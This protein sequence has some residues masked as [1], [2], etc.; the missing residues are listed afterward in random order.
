MADIRKYI[1]VL[2]PFPTP[3]PPAATE[4]VLILNFKSVS[5]VNNSYVDQDFSIPLIDDEDEAETAARIYTGI[6]TVL[7]AQNLLYEDVPSFSDP[8]AAKFKLYQCDHIINVWSEVNFRI[9]VKQLPT[10]TIIEAGNDPVYATLADAEELASLLGVNFVTDAG[11]DYTDEQIAAALRIS[12]QLIR[13]VMGDPMVASI[14]QHTEVGNM[15]TGFH[16]DHIPLIHMPNISGRF[17][18]R[19]ANTGLMDQLSVVDFN[20]D[21]D[22]GFVS[23]AF[24]L[25]MGYAVRFAYVAGQASVIGALRSEA[26]RVSRYLKL[27]TDVKQIKGADFSMT[28]AHQEVKDSIY[29][30]LSMVL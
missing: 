2:K 12:S 13:A 16:V 25:P 11:T 14:Y 7:T 24:E 5:P 22:T 6:N 8:A 28:L 18:F 20:T 1:S 19:V 27:R 4:N 9:K 26:V 23:F 10:N 29:D 17:P 15:Q 21:P 3:D 30:N